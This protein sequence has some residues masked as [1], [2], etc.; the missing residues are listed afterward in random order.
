MKQAAFSSWYLPLPYRIVNTF[1]RII[2]PKEAGF[3]NELS[4][5]LLVCHSLLNLNV[6]H[7]SMAMQK[8]KGEVLELPLASVL[9]TARKDKEG[10]ISCEQGQNCSSTI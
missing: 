6:A 9:I 8:H 7:V 3:I 10:P 4:Y 1:I 5:W 2:S